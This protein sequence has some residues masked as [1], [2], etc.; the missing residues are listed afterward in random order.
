MKK[1]LMAASMM[2]LAAA[3]ACEPQTKPTSIHSSPASSAIAV[4]DGQ[5]VIASEDH[6]Q[7][8]VIDR[9]TR[10]VQ[11]RIDVSAGPA[12]VV[13]NGD[14][15]LVTARYGH[16]LD[17]VDLAAG[18][19]TASIQ[20]G[21]EPYGLTM[22]EDGRVAVTLAG[23]SALAIVNLET[24]SVDRKIDLGTK[25]PRGV[26]QVADGR[27]FVTHMTS[28]QMSVASPGSD[29]VETLDIATRNDFGPQTHPHLIRSLTVAPEGDQVVMAHSQAN[30]QTVRAPIGDGF[31][32]GIGGDCGYSG[33]A[34]ELPA[35]TP[36]VTTVETGTGTVLVPVPG[37][38][39][40]QGAP[41]S[42]A[43]AAD[44]FDC[45][46]FG[47]TFTPNPPSFLNPNENR[48]AGVHIN[49][50][51]AIALFD[52][53]AGSLVL[54]MG[55]QNVLMMK[56]NLTG[57]ASDVLGE[58]KVGNGASD[59][60]IAPEG[61]RAYVWNK[62]DGSVTEFELP[63]V[64]HALQTQS[65][66]VPAGTEVVEAEFREIPEFAGDTFTVVEDAFEPQASLGRKMF[67][68]ALDRRISQSHNISCA[69]CHPDGRSDNNVWQFT[70]GP[71]NTPQLG[72]GILDTAPFHWPGDVED[73]R[74]LNSMTVLAF[75][76]GTG[77]DDA[78]MDAIGA[79]IDTIP[80]APAPNTLQE[81]LTDAQARGQAIFESAETECTNCH[82]GNHLTDNI[83]WNVG[84]QAHANDIVEF[85]TPVLHGLART[86]P[87]MHSGEADT[88]RELVDVL[89]ATDKMGKGSHL[90][91]QEKD[92]L[93]AYLETL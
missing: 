64:S 87:Y 76:G 58:V 18:E 38:G 79:F 92:D 9:E 56:R 77:V 48:F 57:E 3:M 42:G 1:L 8:L 52:G 72:G 33:C 43:P 84:S 7:V 41:N 88:L 20:V 67:H 63:V 89:V 80:A 70:F 37:Q 81:Q 62:F 66:F 60:V 75:M 10:E 12:H 32:D 27:I 4:S 55:T 14:T 13:L 26:A 74:A 28:G 35:V 47:G 54:N 85:Q 24:R 53:G 34:T 73:V 36:T 50:P 5:L 16:S 23:E 2:V 61:D 40:V 83:S 68:S 19:V 65:K 46:F 22:L 78:S 30:T 44:C 69:S 93:A 71:R 21:V 49:N 90:S 59:L 51:Q 11:Q 31:D 45:G 15:A 6:N 39:T 29:R 17:I 82:Y 91:S 86:A 25:D